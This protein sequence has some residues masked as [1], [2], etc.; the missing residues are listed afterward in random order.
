MDY[1]LEQFG[2]LPKWAQAEIKRLTRCNKGLTDRLA[3][4][5]GEKDTN[6]FVCDRL[7]YRPIENNARVEFRT[8]DDSVT[9]HI[10]REGMID[11]N[12]NSWKGK[13]VAILPGY[14]NAF[15]ITFKD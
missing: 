2:R 4:L 15:K 11:I 9:V 5:S 7:T 10:D 13:R 3:E 8:G 12:A 14:S 1:T 6:T